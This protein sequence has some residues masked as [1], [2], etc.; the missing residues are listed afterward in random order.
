MLQE[1][2]DSITNN[3]GITQEKQPIDSAPQP[4]HQE[5]FQTDSD[6][7]YETVE[8]SI[9]ELLLTGKQG[10]IPNSESRTKSAMV[11]PFQNSCCNVHCFCNGPGRWSPSKVILPKDSPKAWINAAVAGVSSIA[12]GWLYYKKVSPGTYMV[13]EIRQQLRW[14]PPTWECSGF[15]F[16]LQQVPDTSSYQC[17]L[18]DAVSQFRSFVPPT[19]VTWTEVPAPNF[20]NSYCRH[21]EGET[22]AKGILSFFFSFTLSLFLFLFSKK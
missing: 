20:R 16:C 18:W 6:V 8:E 13:W 10:T 11:C 4:S 5:K 14:P 19:M 17:L 15:K 2:E 22:E 21:A 9:G 7:Q 3:A 1:K 12:Q